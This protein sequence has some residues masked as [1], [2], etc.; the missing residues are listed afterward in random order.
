MSSISTKTKLKR[1]FYLHK[2]GLELSSEDKEL[3][4]PEKIQ[5]KANKDPVIFG[6]KGAVSMAKLEPQ[7]EEKKAEDCSATSLGSKLLMQF[8]KLSAEKGVERPH[9]SDDDEKNDDDNEDEEEE[10]DYDEIGSDEE[11]D[12]EYGS[13]DY[14]SEQND[15]GDS[16]PLG[17]DEDGPGYQPIEVPIPVDPQG[18]VIVS[19][20]LAFKAKMLFE[21][22]LSRQ[23][24]LKYILQRDPQ[25]QVS[26]YSLLALSSLG[27]TLGTPCLWNG[28]RNCGGYWKP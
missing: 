1:A 7:D 14:E 9:H 11:V 21:D 22:N 17:E 10:D 3:L 23:E 18:K 12:D 26:H 16:L 8:K 5:S 27:C 4:F 15:H 13:S 28:A 6:A 24:K 19:E 25:I 20:D 2:A